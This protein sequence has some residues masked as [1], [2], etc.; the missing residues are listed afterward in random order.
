MNTVCC[1]VKHIGNN[2]SNWNGWKEN[3]FDQCE[4]RLSYLIGVPIRMLDSILTSFPRSRSQSTSNTLVHHVCGFLKIKVFCRYNS[5]SYFQTCPIASKNA[6]RGSTFVIVLFRYS[7]VF[8][9]VCSV[10]QIQQSTLIARQLHSSFHASE[11]W[12]KEIYYALSQ[13]VTIDSTWLLTVTVTL[14]PLKSLS[15]LLD[16]QALIHVTRET[17]VRSDAKS[18]G[19]FFWVFCSR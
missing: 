6:Y 3:Y 12:S 9:D 14:N 4:Y 8:W 11:N 17:G 19:L 2:F 10:E 5:Y 13:H 16:W 18:I 1:W 7:D 15:T